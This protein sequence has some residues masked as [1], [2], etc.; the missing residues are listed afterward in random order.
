MSLYHYIYD[1]LRSITSQALRNKVKSIFK[2]ARNK[3]SLFY[4]LV[5]G[6]FDDRE[7]MEHLIKKIGNNLDILMVHCSHNHLKPMY[8]G[9]IN[10]FLKKLLKYC[11]ENNITIA[12]PAYPFLNTDPLLLLEYYKKHSFNV[13]RDVSK[14]GILSE[15]FRRTSGVK[16]SIHPSH[17]VCAYGSL[18]VKLVSSHYL[19]KTPCGANTPFAIM[20]DHKTKI[21]GIGVHYNRVLTQLHS[22]EDLMESDYPVKKTESEAQY[23]VTCLDE[24]DTMHIMPLS[25]YKNPPKRRAI[26]VKDIIGDVVFEWKFK[27]VNL[28]LTEAKIINERIFAA[29]KE[30]KTIYGSYIIKD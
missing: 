18:A 2:K 17:S 4:I 8:T 20:A 14:M 21:L 7:L 16:R 1:G 19:A 25:Y 23:E 10:N 5:Y 6:R 29:A 28:F 22:A 11:Q 26:D 12:M 30:G 9:N 15:L 13:K 27:G 24:N 3:L